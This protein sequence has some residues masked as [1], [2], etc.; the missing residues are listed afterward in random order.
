MRD[1]VSTDWNCAMVTRVGVKLY[2]EDFRMQWW[3]YILSTD[4]LTAATNVAFD[5]SELM[6]QSHSIVLKGGKD[7]NFRDQ[8]SS[9]SIT[10]V[11]TDK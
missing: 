8:G 11:P 6:I 4:I 7:L 2:D 1:A 9:T 3:I 10:S 5:P